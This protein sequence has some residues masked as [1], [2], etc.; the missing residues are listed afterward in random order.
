MIFVA[1]KCLVLLITLAVTI[2][3]TYV[4]M[5]GIL[6]QGNVADLALMDS[7]TVTLIV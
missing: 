6:V 1:V 7:A 2:L 4:V 3:P 5:P